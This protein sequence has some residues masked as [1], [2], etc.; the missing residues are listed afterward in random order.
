[1]FQWTH[2]DVLCVAVSKHVDEQLWL[3]LCCC[4]CSCCCC[5]CCWC[6]LV[7]RPHHHRVFSIAVSIVVINQTTL[8]RRAGGT[9]TYILTWVSLII[10]PFV[11]F[12]LHSWVPEY[13]L[14]N[15][16]RETALHLLQLLDC[17]ALRGSARTRG[18]RFGRVMYI[19]VKRKVCSLTVGAVSYTHLT[20]PTKRIV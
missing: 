10:F 9:C 8:F 20:L 15:L 1:M 14:S 6:G 5:C 13:L 17:V 18:W 19:R 3:L 16:T 11:F 7:R 4:C 12:R 2:I